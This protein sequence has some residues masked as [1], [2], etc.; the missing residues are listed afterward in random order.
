MHEIQSS[1][2]PMPAHAGTMLRNPKSVY[3]MGDY[4][5]CLA[6]DGKL[7]KTH[8]R[9]KESEGY[10][11]IYEIT[12]TMTGYHEFLEKA[13]KFDS[14][15]V[16]TQYMDD[17]Q[18][19]PRQ[20]LDLMPHRT[21]RAVIDFLIANNSWVKSEGDARALMTTMSKKALLDC[22]LQWIGI[23]GFTDDIIAAVEGI[24]KAK[25]GF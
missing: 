24:Q 4:M 13:R 7:W 2:I 5:V 6:T 19:A 25:Q 14:A 11:I 12:S 16:T 22:Y 10:P 18:W 1:I 15:L 23:V 8:R 17:D 20:D 3:T 9:H 21:L